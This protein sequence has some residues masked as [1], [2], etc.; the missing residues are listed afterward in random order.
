M[1]DLIVIGA[2]SGGLTAAEFAAQLGLKVALVEKDKI[3]GDCTWT[4]CVPSKALLH[5][6]K[7][8]QSVR[9]ASRMGVDSSA[10]V[11]DMKR[12]KGYVQTAVQTVYTQ[13]TPEKLEAKGIDVIFGSAAFVDGNTVELDG[14]RRLSAKKFVLAT[15]AHPHVPP[16]SGLADV[17]FFTYEQIFENERLPNHLLIL[18]AGPIGVEIGQS[19]GRLGAKV[20][21]IDPA[22]LLP[23]IDVEARGVMGEVLVDEGVDVVVGEVTAVSQ[24]SQH[25]I[26]LQLDKQIVQGDMLL[27]AT[28]RRPNVDNLGLAEAGID[29]SERGIGVSQYLQ[30]SVPHIYAVG[31]CIGGAQATHLAGWQGFQA[32]RNAFLPRQSRGVL[33]A[34]PYTIFTDPEIASMGMSEAK[35]RDKYGE[36]LQITQTSLSQIDR[37]ITDDATQGFIKLLHTKKGEILGATIIGPRAGEMITEFILAKKHNLSVQDVAST[38]HVYPSYS[39]GV[40][41]LLSKRATAD[42][43]NS[44]MGRLFQRFIR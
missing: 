4:G 12:V 35:A 18:G 19:Y 6:A 40:Q 34:V 24:L 10:P 39:M 8:A 26:E 13:E 37:A 41:R 36:I 44:N 38:M 20:T 11:V 32:V 27:V 9:V 15:G 14:Q 25:D 17:P 1:Y 33:T 7:T 22:G 31:D 3:G 16:I 29:Y 5:V 21:L 30:T 42:F 43:L 28:G 23:E 2:G